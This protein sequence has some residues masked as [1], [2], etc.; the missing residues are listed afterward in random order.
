MKLARVAALAAKEWR[1]IVRDRMFL[2]LAF[3][4][5]AV[6]MVVCVYGSVQTLEDVPLAVVDHDRTET[7]RRYAER[8]ASTVYFRLAG[9][10]ESEREA[11]DLLAR[12]E[13]RVVLVL[14]E[15]LERRVREGRSAVVQTWIDGSYT[16][17]APPRALQGYVEAVNGAATAELQAGVL[18]RRLGVPAEDALALLRPVRLEVRYLYNPQLRAVW[19]AAPALVMFILMF[20]APLLMAL[21]V[22]REKESG[23]ILNIHASTVTRAEFLAGKLLPNVAIACANTVVLWGLAVGW[24]GAPFRGSL[25]LFAVAALL[26]AVAT[27]SIGLVVSLLVRTQSTAMIATV[28][29]AVLVGNQFSGMQVPVESLSPVSRA[30]AHLFPPMYFYD[31]VQGLFL[32][33]MSAAALWREVAALAVFAVAYP[34]LAWLLFHKRVRA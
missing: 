7:S 6:L 32:K 9:Y 1:E 10:V 30:L 20:V 12:S 8:F 13:V 31:V 28:V 17:S 11:A 29:F 5:P 23:S 19:T 21:G 14:P 18:S 26:Y 4:L 33:G 16:S 25:L 2:A 22:V 15:E 34:C 27:P 3:L 24:F